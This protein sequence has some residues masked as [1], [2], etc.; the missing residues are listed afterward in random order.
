M[1]AYMK[2]LIRGDEKAFEQL[3][4][5]NQNKIYAVC[6]NM[7]KNEHDA[8]DAAQDA[9]IKAYRSISAFK[10]ESKVETWL[11]KI[12]VNTCLDILRRRREFYD[13]SEAADAADSVTPESETEKGEVKQLVRASISKLPP[14]MRSIVVL[15]DI[16]GYSYEEIADMLKLN[17]GTVR[18]RLSR[19]REKLKQIFLEKREL[20]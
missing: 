2:K 14:D 20:F 12:A 3:V 7:L 18:S 6:L 8:Q 10:G 13:L 1:D 19:A 4:R 17:I 16:E 11:T 5:A 15:R 9:F